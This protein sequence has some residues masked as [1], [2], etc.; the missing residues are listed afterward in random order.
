MF[1]YCWKPNRN[2]LLKCE[3]I[4][5]LADMTD[6]SKYLTDASKYSHYNNSQMHHRLYN[7]AADTNNTFESTTMRKPMVN[8]HHNSVPNLLPKRR[9]F[10]LTNSMVQP[11]QT[12]EP[13]YR[14]GSELDKFNRIPDL[15]PVK[16]DPTTSFN[17][18]YSRIPAINLSGRFNNNESVRVLDP[19]FKKPPSG[20]VFAKRQ[21]QFPHL[22]QLFSSNVSVIHGASNAFNRT[23]LSILIH[24][25][26]FVWKKKQHTFATTVVTAD[27]TDRNE[28]HE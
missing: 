2:N 16:R 19:P 12:V 11:Q 7:G 27:Q 8:G 9:I 10:Q 20:S 14:L 3:T 15:C 17:D 5:F 28:Q 6:T 22:S 13:M 4:C 18:N 25:F 21:A 1:I 23:H 26:C 24:L